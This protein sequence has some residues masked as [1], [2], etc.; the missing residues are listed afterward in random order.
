MKPQKIFFV[1]MLCF[2]LQS[3]TP[4][5]FAAPS[6]IKWYSYEE[7]MAEGKKQGKKIF[8]TFRADWCGYCR[9]MEKETFKDPSVIAYLTEHFISIKVDTD[10]QKNLA[11]QYRVTGLPSNWFLTKTGEPIGNRP[12]YMATD[13]FLMVLKSLQEGEKGGGQT[14]AR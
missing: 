2:F 3:V 7:G 8:I 10:R 6:D 13:V 5:C 1:L 4:P 9:K 14:S 12:G 11:V